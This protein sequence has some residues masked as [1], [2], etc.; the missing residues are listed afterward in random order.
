M[1][2]RTKIGALGSAGLVA[3]ALFS[4][5]SATADIEG[6]FTAGADADLV[7]ASGISLPPGCG[8]EDPELFGLDGGFDCTFQLGTLRAGDTETGNSTAGDLSNGIEDGLVSF[9]HA[10]NFDGEALTADDVVGN[11]SADFITSADAY[12]LGGPT[13]DSDQLGATPENDLLYADGMTVDASA[14]DISEGNTQCPEG[15]EIRLSH[16]R[17]E[18]AN[19]RLGPDQ[20]PEGGDVVAAEGVSFAHS[21]VDLVDALVAGE[22]Y[23]LRSSAATDLASISL[24]GGNITL[25]AIQPRLVGTH[26]GENFS[27]EYTAPDVVLT[28]GGEEILDGT[29]LDTLDEELLSELEDQLLDELITGEGA[30][31]P[32]LQVNLDIKQTEDVE[33]AGNS[34]T[35]SDVVLLEIVLI[36]GAEDFDF[37]PI[38]VLSLSV[39]DLSVSAEAPEGGVLI[40]CALPP[41]TVE[42]DGPE[43]VQPGETFTYTIDVTNETGCDVTEV[44]VTDEITGPDGF[45]VTG[46]SPAADSVEGGTVTWTVGD[47]AA[48]DTETFTVDIRVPDSATVG[49][50]FA[51][52]ATASGNCDGR[53]LPLGSD[54]LDGPAVQVAAAR[55]ESLPR[56]G[57]GF[58]LLGLAAAAA[59]GAL[60]RR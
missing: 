52:T 32:L 48:G 36:S 38:E 54:T 23:G 15:D 31:T 7:E 34:A 22:G 56:T 2:R 59:A 44:V 14:T 43:S 46:T 8:V 39:G 9:G 16:G 45:E 40:D 11:L 30:L 58:A 51:D 21:Q 29:I 10:S 1:R 35:V 20:F 53:A 5:L 6:T 37:E 24:F 49:D 25:D 26:D 42:K 60:R 12:Q 27:F 47:M 57:G 3:I 28:A 13:E 33:V 55:T 17:N 50:M 41:L 4:P 19:L 18:L